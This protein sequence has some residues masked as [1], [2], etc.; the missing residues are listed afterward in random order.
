[1][2]A[3][4]KTVIAVMALAAAGCSSPHGHGHRH[5]QQEITVR[6]HKGRSLERVVT[7]A[8]VKQRWVPRKASGNTVR[9]TIARAGHRVSVDVVILR[10]DAYT[11]RRVYS[12]IPEKAYNQLVA[13]LMREIAQIAAA[14]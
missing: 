2:S 7:A 9:C 12:D 5:S 3:L 6:M 13:N 8:A 11:V 4:F 10:W 14:R 1:M